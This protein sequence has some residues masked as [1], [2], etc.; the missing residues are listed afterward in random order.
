MV[1]VASG[2]VASLFLVAAAV[3]TANMDQ[4]EAE[5]SALLGGVRF[6]GIGRWLVITE[7]ALGSALAVPWELLFPTNLLMPRLV[8]ASAG[9]VLVG[10]GVILASTRILVGPRPCGCLGS[11][12]QGTNSWR[13]AVINVVAGAIVVVLAASAEPLQDGYQSALWRTGAMSA[14]LLVIVLTTVVWP[15]IANSR[16]ISQ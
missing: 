5:L 2:V 8:V 7:M 13:H 1:S 16:R 3:K 11:I 12:S 14:T 15:P 6:Q 10:F 4:L 9:A